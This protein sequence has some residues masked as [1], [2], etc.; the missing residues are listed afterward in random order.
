MWRTSL[1]YSWSPKCTS[2]AY[3]IKGGIHCTYQDSPLSHLFAR[4]LELELV[5]FSA[6]VERYATEVVE[7]PPDSLCLSAAK[8]EVEV[9]KRHTWSI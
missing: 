7:W 3:A 5:D 8:R 1:L 9:L 2:Y 4:E 6:L